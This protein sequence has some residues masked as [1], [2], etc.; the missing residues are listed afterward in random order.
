MYLL[1]LCSLTVAAIAIDR[2]LLYRRA[3]QGG[4]A[5]EADVSKSLRAKKINELAPAVEGQDNMVAYL[6]KTAL[7]A[8]AAGENI[9]MALDAAYGEAAML[10]RARLNYLSMIVTMAPLMGLLGTISGMIQSFSIF[11]LQAGQPMA[12]TGG[13]GEALIATATGLF[14]AIFSLVVHTYFAQRMDTMLTLLE[15]TINTL[16]AGFAVIDGGS[17]HAP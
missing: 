10:L 3:S 5:L 4:R 9:S 17:R 2:F 12:I 8:R 13:I 11:N 15:K 16:Q 6:V 7:D 1:L 14:V